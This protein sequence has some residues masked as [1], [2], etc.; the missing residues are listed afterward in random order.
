MPC[1]YRIF[2]DMNLIVKTFS[3]C[4][5]T[6]CVLELLDRVEEDPNFRE[7]MAEL[8][9]LRDVVDLAI[10]ATDI[11]HFAAMVKG[12]SQGK[13]RPT[14]KAVIAPSGPARIAAQGFYSE[15][16]GTKGL[17]VGVFGDVKDALVFLSIPA[18]DFARFLETNQISVH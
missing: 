17:E 4:V 7:G 18:P 1:E 5:T 9:D 14:K 16:E 13:R 11:G 6:K 8:D 2:A 3:G 12:F 15:V 10:T